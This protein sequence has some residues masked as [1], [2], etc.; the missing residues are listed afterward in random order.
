[1]PVYNTFWWTSFRIPVTQM[2][3]LN[4]LTAGW[5]EG[6]GRSAR[7]DPMQS[8]YRFAVQKWLVPQMQQQVCW[9]RLL[10][11]ADQ[12]PFHAADCEL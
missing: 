2:S 3:L 11:I 4:M 5:S 1:M 9:V 8:I 6:D 7:G 12:F 10:A